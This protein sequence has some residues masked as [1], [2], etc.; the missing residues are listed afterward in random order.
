VE[1]AGDSVLH[2]EGLRRYADL[3]D[4]AAFAYDGFPFSRVPDLGET[5][6]VVPARA[7][8]RELSIV[9]T[10]LAQLAQVTGRVG[11]RA[12]FLAGDPADADLAGRDLLVVGAADASPLLR[13][14]AA[15]LPL[16]FAG[17][18]ARVERPLE[19]RAVVDLLGGAGPL[20]DAR[21]AADVLGTARGA[22]AIV[23]IESPVSRGRE[24]V[25]V[26]AASASELP[27]FRTFLGYAESRGRGGDLL[28]SAGDARWLFRIG[29][30]FGR[31][32]LGGWTRLRWFLANHWIALLPLLAAGVA[33][34]ALQLR[35]LLDARMRARLAPEAAP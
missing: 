34:L 10:A 6:V 33:A 35:A 21:R 31:G 32:E 29:P 2:L 12:T 28:V 27:P 19:P 14:W 16:S 7:T 1:I 15:H 4:V 25:F 30:T 26:T 20:L 24:V 18:A 9:L 13:R 22:A 17:G 11:T 8:A 3:P 5:A 23:G